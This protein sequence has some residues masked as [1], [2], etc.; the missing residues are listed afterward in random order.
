VRIER[1]YADGLRNLRGVELHP[2]PRFN[3]LAGANG[4][5]KTNTL[6]A[7]WLLS[8]LRS[9]RTR[10]L[11]ECVD[12]DR[13]T[14]LGAE[15]G[16]RVHSHGVSVDLGVRI[17]GKRTAM[18]VDGKSG[19]RARDYLGKLV[20]VLFVADDLR[21]PHGEPAMRRRY[22]DRAIWTHDRG[23][24]AVMRAYEKALSNRNALLRDHIGRPIDAGMLDVFDDMVS[25][26]GAALAQ[27]RA[28]FVQGFSERVAREFEAFAP[29]GLTCGLR[30]DARAGAESKDVAE[31]TSMLSE[32]LAARRDTDRRRGHT[33]VGPHLDD[34]VLMLGGRPARIHASQGQCR[35]MVLAMKIAELRSLESAHGEPPI[36]LMDDVSSELDAVRNAALMSHLDALGGQVLMTTTDAA[37]IRVT[38][39]TAVF[40]VQ[41]GVVTPRPATS[42]EANP[43]TDLPE[44]PHAGL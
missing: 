23:F 41:A 42:T 19:T 33:S 22:L 27:R 21:L 32:A 36:L 30:Y 31:R 38:A 17:G 6:E 5:G 39:P 8:C 10:K 11:A 37:Y 2:H 35:A 24:L 34:L 4:Q 20:V 44:N 9:F 12:F 14:E 28:D 43:P 16:A 40:D 1:L 25:S 7:I 29:A 3:V 13:K 18:F 15:L 26:K